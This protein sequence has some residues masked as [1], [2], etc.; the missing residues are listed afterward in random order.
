[1]GTQV[2]ESTAEA[3]AESP[4]SPELQTLFPDAILWVLASPDVVEVMSLTPYNSYDS[5]EAGDASDDDGAIPD[6]PGRLYGHSIRGAARVPTVDR[7]QELTRALI[8]ANREGN[9]WALC[10]DPHYAVR[11]SRGGR[12]LDFLIC[13]WCGNVRVVAPG[14]DAVTYP[15]G[16]APAPARAAPRRGGLA[17]VLASVATVARATAASD[18]DHVPR[19][20]LLS[21]RPPRFHVRLQRAYEW[22]TSRLPSQRWLLRPGP[23]PR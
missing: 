19:F 3:L 20:P 23:V 5:N 17:V 18:R 14:S 2:P 4:S 9:G 1:M 8:A 11:V 7:R 16:G 10:F 12:T 13:F 22:R 21:A 6:S 15:F